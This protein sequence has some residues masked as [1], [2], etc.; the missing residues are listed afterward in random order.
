MV[1]AVFYLF[2]HIEVELFYTCLYWKFTVIVEFI[3]INVSFTLR[4]LSFNVETL[5]ICIYSY[6]NISRSQDTL[7]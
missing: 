7:P 3:I 6:I 5:I 2:N 1:G 4:Q